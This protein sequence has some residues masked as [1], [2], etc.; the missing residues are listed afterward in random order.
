MEEKESYREP[1]QDPLHH[2]YSPRN[3][4]NMACHTL[5]IKGLM[6][7]TIKDNRPITIAITVIFLFHL[8]SFIFSAS[9]FS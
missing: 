1:Y 6:Q 4:D 5:S 9:C 8:L 2:I 7:A 3:S